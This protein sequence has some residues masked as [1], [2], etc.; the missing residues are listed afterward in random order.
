[1]DL[2]LVGMAPS[3]FAHGEPQVGD[4][5]I[6]RALSGLPSFVQSSSKMMQDSALFA[7]I[8]MDEEICSSTKS[9]RSFGPP[10]TTVCTDRMTQIV[11][12]IINISSPLS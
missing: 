7:I 9:T 12:P 1:M 5:G 3:Q 4:I 10:T 2:T 6:K 11:S 8:E